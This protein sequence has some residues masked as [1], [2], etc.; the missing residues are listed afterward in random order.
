[1]YQYVLDVPGGRRGAV[2]H[3]SSPGNI[4]KQSHISASRHTDSYKNEPSSLCSLSS[5]TIIM[6]LKIYGFSHS[7][8]TR[9]VA[10]VCKE[11][12]I[13]YE[14]VPID[15]AKREHKSPEFIKNQPFGQV[16]YIVR[17]TTSSM[18]GH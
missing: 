16:P 3:V 12:E 5:L 11:K 6:V 17:R 18:W 10:V 8:C 7:T 9:L 14:L 2:N 4:S 1:M 15:L 13:P